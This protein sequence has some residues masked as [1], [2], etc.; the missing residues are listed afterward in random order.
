[1]TA[2]EM[3]MIAL[4]MKQPAMHKGLHTQLNITTRWHAHEA[5]M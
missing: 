5:T 1:M 4:M 3:K 2:I